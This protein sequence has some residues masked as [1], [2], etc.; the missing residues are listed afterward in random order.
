MLVIRRCMFLP[1]LT[2]TCQLWTVSLKAGLN[3]YKRHAGDGEQCPLRSRC[4]PR[5]KRG[6]R[7]PKER[8]ERFPLAVKRP[9]RE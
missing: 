6:V 7:L 8:R 9:E 4:P 2:A 5:L 3:T 1:S